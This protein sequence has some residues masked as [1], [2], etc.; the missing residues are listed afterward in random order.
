MSRL[1]NTLHAIAARCRFWSNNV[2]ELG[3]AKDLRTIA[4]DLDREAAECEGVDCPSDE[5]LTQ[6]RRTSSSQ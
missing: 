1:S 5:G 6:R 2:I 4:A 3:A